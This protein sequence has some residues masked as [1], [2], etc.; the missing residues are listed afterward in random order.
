MYV[1]SEINNPRGIKN[2]ASPLSCP[3]FPVASKNRKSTETICSLARGNKPGENFRFAF[4][5]RFISPSPFS[6]RIL[7]STLTGVEKKVH[8]LRTD[9]IKWGNLVRR[10]LERI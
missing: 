10:I 9:R 1:Q 4:I 5:P 3:M 6:R 7:P 2:E 8:D